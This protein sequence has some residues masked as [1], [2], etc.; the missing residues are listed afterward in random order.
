MFRSTLRGLEKET[1]FDND[2]NEQTTLVGKMLVK[3][4]MIMDYQCIISIVK[5]LRI[6]MIYIC[7]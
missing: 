1:Y 6:I 4:T 2:G 5:T 7:R 3:R